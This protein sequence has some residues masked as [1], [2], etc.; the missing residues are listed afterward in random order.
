MIWLKFETFILQF[1]WHSLK[2]N[3]HNP[4]EKMSDEMVYKHV[5]RLS[6][7]A[8]YL[9]FLS[10][11]C[12]VEGM[13]FCPNKFQGSPSVPIIQVWMALRSFL[14][15]TGMKFFASSS[16]IPLSCVLRQLFLI[17]ILKLELQDSTVSGNLN[18]NIEENRLEIKDSCL[19][20]PSLCPIAGES[21][22]VFWE[23]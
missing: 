8:F 13:E 11:H 1:F 16:I 5:F 4:Q 7:L 9:L 15:I 2:N 23:H 12:T 14:T 10:N 22:G 18:H 17:L 19:Q 3:G 21:P 6:W 20:S